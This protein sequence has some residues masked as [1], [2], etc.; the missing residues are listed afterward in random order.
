VSGKVEERIR[1]LRAEGL[2]IL[3]VAKVLG[4]GVSVVQRIELAV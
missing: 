1:A 3:K 4:R 2:G